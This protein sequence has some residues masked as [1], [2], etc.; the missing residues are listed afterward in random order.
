MLFI[1]RTARFSEI[2]KE[3]IRA[4]K[5]QIIFLDSNTQEGFTVELRSVE[6]GELMSQNTNGAKFFYCDTVWRVYLKDGKSHDIEVKHG[7][8]TDIFYPESWDEGK[9]PSSPVAIMTT[10]CSYNGSVRLGIA[11]DDWVTIERGDMVCGAG[12]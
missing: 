3:D 1:Y 6:K 11:C 8:V 12:K 9:N 4:K 10:G 2:V 5:S 7:K